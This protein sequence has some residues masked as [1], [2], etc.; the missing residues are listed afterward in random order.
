MFAT[1]YFSQLLATPK[2]TSRQQL[3]PAPLITANAESQ[4][5]STHSCLPC[6]STHE[7]SLRDIIEAADHGTC[8]VGVASQGGI[9]HGNPL[10]QVVVA[11]QGV[12]LQKS[13]L[14]VE[15]YQAWGGAPKV[16]S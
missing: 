8:L 12:N 11:Y 13:S 3:L 1:C 7:V 15:A 2:Q 4:L 16:R 5:D 6:L 14:G 10:A 9:A